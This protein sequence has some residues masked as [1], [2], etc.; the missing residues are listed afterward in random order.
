MSGIAG[1]RGESN[2]QDLHGD[3]SI[4]ATVLAH[5]SRVWSL[6]LVH[7]GGPVIG[8]FVI[9]VAYRFPLVIL[10]HVAAPMTP[11]CSWEDDDDLNFHPEDLYD[12]SY[13]NLDDLEKFGSQDEED[14]YEEDECDDDE[15]LDDD[16]EDEVDS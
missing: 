3:D 12:R 9:R 7:E 5:K 4:M 6:L 14:E 8:G 11:S 1:I 2:T 13:G 16:E 15:D 10:A